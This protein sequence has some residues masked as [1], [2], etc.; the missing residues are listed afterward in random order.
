[1]RRAR[2]AGAGMLMWMALLGAGRGGGETV[3]AEI[4]LEPSRPAT[5][6][7]DTGATDEAVLRAMEAMLDDERQT[8]AEYERVVRDHGSVA[9]FAEFARSERAHAE[10]IVY[11]FRDRKLAVPQNRWTPDNVRG[12]RTLR[13]ACAAALARANRTIAQYERYRAMPL[14]EDVL[15]AFNHNRRVTRN[16]HLP[17]LEACALGTPAG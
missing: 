15:R 5:A 7:A 8:A 2:Q 11:L 16:N 13:E 10:F 1:M 9:P 14:P 12:Y 17:A 3:H 4:I 6:V